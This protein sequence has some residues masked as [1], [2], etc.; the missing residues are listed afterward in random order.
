MRK[1]ARKFASQKKVEKAAFIGLKKKLDA[2]AKEQQDIDVPN[3]K[4]L[5]KDVMKNPDG[6][7]RVRDVLASV[8]KKDRPA[9]LKN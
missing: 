6:K 9:D 1:A 7:K 2:F 3:L 5:L 8:A 4:A